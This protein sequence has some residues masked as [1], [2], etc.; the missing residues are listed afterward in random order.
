MPLKLPT[1]A[2]KPVTSWICNIGYFFNKWPAV[3]ASLWAASCGE[4]VVF[5]L[6]IKAVTCVCSREKTRCTTGCCWTTSCRIISSSTC[7]VA[8]PST[9]R[10]SPTRWSNSVR[11][12]LCSQTSWLCRR[13][14]TD[15]TSLSGVLIAYEGLP[16]HLT[17]I[18]KLWTELCQSQV[19]SNS[20]HRAVWVV[21]VETKWVRGVLFYCF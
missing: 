7:S 17:L 6:S 3:S 11:I 12:R 13:A 14:Q 16:L 5:C 10:S 15:R 18:P 8:S 4:G 9:V 2:Y 1:A 20:V 19:S 21:C